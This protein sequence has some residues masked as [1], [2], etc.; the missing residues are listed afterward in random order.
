MLAYSATGIVQDI[1]TDDWCSSSQID[2]AIGNFIQVNQLGNTCLFHLFTDKREVGFEIKFVRAYQHRIAAGSHAALCIDIL[3]RKRLL[4]AV[5]ADATDFLTVMDEGKAVGIMDTDDDILGMRAFKIA[6][7]R[8]SP[9]RANVLHIAEDL[10]ILTCYGRASADP[11]QPRRRNR[12]DAGCGGN[13]HAQGQ[14]LPKHP[15]C[16]ASYDNRKRHH[17]RNPS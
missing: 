6:K 3:A 14:S 15:S 17:D 12:A 2:D 7:G 16:R 11:Y 10:L 13:R 4:E 9:E 5:G 1:I 8:V